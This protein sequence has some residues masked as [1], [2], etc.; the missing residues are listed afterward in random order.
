M[1]LYSWIFKLDKLDTEKVWMFWGHSENSRFWGES[2]NKGKRR[3]RLS[4]PS[5]SQGESNCTSLEITEM[6]NIGKPPDKYVCERFHT[7]ISV[8]SVELSRCC[9]VCSFSAVI[10]TWHRNLPKHWCEV[11]SGSCNGKLRAATRGCGWLGRAVVLWEA[12]RG[13]LQSFWYFRK[14]F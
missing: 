10:I 3:R 14:P 13:F 11:P 6:F 1:K 2:H 7:H 8:H 4:E 12:G 5:G 9:G